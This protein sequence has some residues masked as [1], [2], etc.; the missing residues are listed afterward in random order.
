MVKVRQASQ[1]RHQAP[2]LLGA[3]HSSGY[4]EAMKYSLLIL[5]SN[6]PAITCMGVAG[7]LASQGKNGWGWFLIVGMICVCSVTLGKQDD[8]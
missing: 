6:I 4:R 2:G 5:S 1:L 8:K 3:H 7:H